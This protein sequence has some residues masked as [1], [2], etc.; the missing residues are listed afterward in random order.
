MTYRNV[1]VIKIVDAGVAELGDALDSKSSGPRVRESS[2]LSSGTISGH[3][4]VKR[5]QAVIMKDY[6]LF[7]G[8]FQKIDRTQ[9]KE[10]WLE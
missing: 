7:F 3:K 9:G 6:G 5:E 2:N 4:H 1:L 10:K 8:R